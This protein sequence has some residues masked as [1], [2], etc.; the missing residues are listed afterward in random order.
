[1]FAEGRLPMHSRLGMQVPR[2]GDFTTGRETLQRA[3][4]TGDFTNSLVSKEEASDTSSQAIVWNSLPYPCLVHL[5]NYP[6]KICVLV[7][8]VMSG[9][10]LFFI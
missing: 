4:G 1:M 7:K 3:P 10:E 9:V 8:N 6:A 2:N 5:V